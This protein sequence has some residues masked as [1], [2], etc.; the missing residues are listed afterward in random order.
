MHLNWREYFT[1]VT[2]KKYY[3][4]FSNLRLSLEY[5][6]ERAIQGK[7]V[8]SVFVPKLGLF[9]YKNELIAARNLFKKGKSEEGQNQLN[10]SKI[11]V[12]IIRRTL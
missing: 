10:Y 7:E 6:N 9:N 11:S 8:I 2:L 5:I 4:Y 3:S 1:S 12:A